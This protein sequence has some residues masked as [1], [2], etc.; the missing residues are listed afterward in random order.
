M[1]KILSFIL[2]VLFFTAAILPINAEKTDAVNNSAK[3]SDGNSYAEYIKKYADAEY[4]DAETVIKAEDYSFVSSDSGVRSEKYKGENALIWESEK[5]YADYS[6]T[7]NKTALYAVRFRYCPIEHKK[8]DIIMYMQLDG[9]LPFSEAGQLVLRKQYRP[10]GS[11]TQNADGDDISPEFSEY[12]VWSESRAVNANYDGE[13]LF[14]LESGTHTLRLGITQEYAALSEI[15]FAAPEYIPSYEEYAA[16]YGDKR[17]S[18]YSQTFEAENIAVQSVALNLL[19]TDKSSTKTS[20]F[21]YNSS[22]LNIAGGEN[23]KSSGQWVEWNIEVPE[24]GFYNLDMRY[25]QSYAPGRPTLRRLYINGE[26]PFSEALCISFDYCSGWGRCLITD[27]DGN[28]LP[29]WLKKGKNTLRLEVTEGENADIIRQTESIVYTLNQIYRS[30]IMITGSSPDT[31]RDYELE[32]QIPT[33]IPT[34]EQVITQLN[35]IYGYFSSLSENANS[36]NIIQVLSKQLKSFINSPET[37]AGRVSAFSSNIGSLSSWASELK[38]QS[39]D[40]DYIRVSSVGSEKPDINDSIFESVWRECRMFLHSFISN[41]GSAGKDGDKDGIVVWLNS[42]RDQASVIKRLAEE[43]FEPES[44]ISV[45]LKLV[46]ANLIQAFLSGNS[47][48]VMVLVDR[49]IPVDLA[50][51]GALLDLKQF[52]DFENAVTDYQSTALEPYM[53]EDG[54]YGLPDS[55]SF[56]MM[57]Y[58]TDILSELEI[59]PPRTWDDF[60]AAVE[61]IQRHNMTIGVPYAGVDASGA[62]SSGIGTKN[63]FSALLLQNGGT[64]FND[65]F[66]ETAFSSET[67][68][69]AF[70]EWTELYSEYGL[71]ISYNFF[72]RFR[73][74][75]M[76]LAIEMYTSYN[77]LSVAA[78]EIAGQW[79]MTAI[80]GTLRSDGVIDRSEGAAGTACVISKTTEKK[81]EAWE[82]VKFWVGEKSQ[83]RYASDIEAQLGV[84]GR[85]APAN[86]KALENMAWTAS[87]CDAINSQWKWI[88]EIRN[89]PGGYYVVRGLDNAFRDVVYN[90]NDPYRALASWDKE[91]N[92][93]IAR[94]REEFH[95]D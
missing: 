40:L 18:G 43:S 46:S 60:I 90:S 28:E 25:S 85:F 82:F 32:K 44:G 47:P 11:I 51:R 79:E 53:F 15:V 59:Q 23:W 64:F 39:L 29:I 61:I 20:P 95:L 12:C 17:P 54:C 38:A 3:I 70:K 16:S 72:N 13:L 8:L 52:P 26:T 36:A 49:G 89:V 63:I 37:I 35:G 48:D 22:R 58:R 6:F 88:K 69:R 94:K 66:S 68:K 14:Y 41:Y 87:E 75:E 55:Q 19:Q 1:K 83:S 2:A 74:G 84:G 81:D 62:A 31:Y 65:R 71:D 27:K 56:Y 42:G 86:M 93:E 92:N 7:V 4:A 24:E 45:K 73:T 30:I 80:P 5:G 77:Q 57:F 91:I 33:L 21:S 50:L 67:A 9:E 76:P 78:P 10:T 34:F